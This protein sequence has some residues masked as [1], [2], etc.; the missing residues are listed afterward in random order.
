MQTLQDLT[1]TRPFTL[2]SKHHQDR[3]YRG[4]WKWAVM[5]YPTNKICLN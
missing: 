2:W 4:Q 1:Q 3:R 5:N